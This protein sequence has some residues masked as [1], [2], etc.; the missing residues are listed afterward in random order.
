LGKARINE[1]GTREVDITSALRWE[2]DTGE[3]RSRLSQPIDPFKKIA[4][5]AREYEER[6][7]IHK[8]NEM[9][10]VA[11]LP[12][13]VVMKI[14][15]EHGIDAMNLHGEK[16]QKKLLQVIQSE[17]PHLMTTNQKVHRRQGDK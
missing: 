11:S 4:E 13:V 12:I 14:K 7:G 1:F 15:R 17:Y 6:V 5:E 16:E 9:R 10:R 8:N 2:K 3:V